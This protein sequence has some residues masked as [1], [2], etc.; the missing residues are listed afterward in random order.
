MAHVLLLLLVARED[1]DLADVA[2]QK[3]A[4]HRIAKTAGAA[5]NEEGVV[6]DPAATE[7]SQ[8]TAATGGRTNQPAKELQAL[9]R[10]LCVEKRA[11]NNFAT[12][13]GCRM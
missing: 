4:E 11:V 1:A 10:N 9:Y 5:G 8:S 12:V 7:T 2:F 3:T 6:L 13:L